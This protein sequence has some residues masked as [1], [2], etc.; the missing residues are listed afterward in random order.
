MILSRTSLLAVGCWL[1]IGT[2]GGRADDEQVKAD[3]EAV[4]GAGLATDGPALVEFF[5]QRT[6]GD[7]VR[8]NINALVGKLGHRSYRVRKRPAAHLSF[9]GR[10]PSAASNRQP[11]AATW[12]LSAAQGAASTRSTRASSPS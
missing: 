12:K 6:P 4:R 9:S 1:L 11:K 2:V 5:R 7:N 10:P 8:Q 3:E